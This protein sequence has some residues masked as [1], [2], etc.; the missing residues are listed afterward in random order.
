M[1]KA[2]AKV[3]RRAA[4][5]RKALVRKIELMGIALSNGDMATASNHEE[6]AMALLNAFANDL[7]KL[8]QL[9]VAASSTEPKVYLNLQL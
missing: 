9:R 2:Q 6:S 1:L 5:R 3:E 4:M 7:Q 8:E